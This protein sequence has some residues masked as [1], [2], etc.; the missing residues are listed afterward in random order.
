[1]ASSL[2]CDFDCWNGCTP[3]FAEGRTVSSNRWLQLHR[4]A[5]SLGQPWQAPWQAGGCHAFC[6]SCTAS[7]QG[8]AA[9]K[10]MTGLL[11]VRS[12]IPGGRTSSGLAG[13][14]WSCSRQACWANSMSHGGLVAYPRPQLLVHWVH[15]HWR[16]LHVYVPQLQVHVVATENVAPISA[17]LDVRNA[18]D[19]LAEERLAALQGRA[20]IQAPRLPSTGSVWSSLCDWGG[21]CRCCCCTGN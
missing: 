19:D 14:T 15:S 17:E 18:A 16:C 6:R 12:C 5:A 10:L 8:Q 20:V 1:M 13:T 4:T 3:S 21:G 2:A 9:S 7:Q 11:G